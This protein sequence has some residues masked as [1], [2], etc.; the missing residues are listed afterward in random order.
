M[1][2]TSYEKQKENYLNLLQI[3][4]DLLNDNVEPDEIVEYLNAKK[5]EELSRAFPFYALFC[6]F[7]SA[8]MAWK[9]INRLSSFW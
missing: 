5:E 6:S 3:A 9:N 7:L 2:E 1:K 4:E 8:N